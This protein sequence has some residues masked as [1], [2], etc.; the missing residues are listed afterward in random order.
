MSNRL[1]LIIIGLLVAN[2]VVGIVKPSVDTA[3][4]NDDGSVGL[5][6]PWFIDEALASDER[7]NRAI[8]SIA[9]EAGISAYVKTPTAI[10]LSRAKTAFS[11]VTAENSN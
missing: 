8:A 6:R 4:I 7:S 9:D 3:G 10:L 11:S 5:V 2:L 1:L